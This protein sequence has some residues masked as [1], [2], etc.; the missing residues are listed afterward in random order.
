MRLAVTVHDASRGHALAS[1]L[2]DWDAR[3]VKHEDVWIVEVETGPAD[4]LAVVATVRAWLEGTTSTTSSWKSTGRATPW[5]P[6]DPRVP[7]HSDATRRL[8][9]SR[10][11]LL[12]RR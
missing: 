12:V 3:L 4:A 1:R 5:T 7:R 11:W 6:D 8:P 2:R 10:K 9:R